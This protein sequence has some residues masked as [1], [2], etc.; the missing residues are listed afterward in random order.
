MLGSII[1]SKERRKMKDEGL[2]RPTIYSDELADKICNLLAEGKSLNTICKD[3]DMPC[4][5][6]I[7]NW[8]D[9]HE[10]FLHK[11]A[12][13]KQDSADA[14]VDSIMDLA[15]MK[16]VE[17]TDLKYYTD[18]QG[19]R[20]VDAQLLK[21][22]LDALKWTASKLK[23]QTYGADAILALQQGGDKKDLRPVIIVNKET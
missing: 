1:A 6:T 9:Q 14:H 3:E 16:G 23:P 11:Y 17:E 8:L 18:A 19:N 13:A 2:G 21:V 20:R 10:I 4:R 12:K 5:K 15:F 7:Y 22:Q